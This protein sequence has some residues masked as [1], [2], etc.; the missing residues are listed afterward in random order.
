MCFSN[1]AIFYVKGVAVWRGIK[2]TH[3]LLKGATKL[4]QVNKV[5][6]MY[7]KRGEYINALD[8]FYKVQ[9]TDVRAFSVRQI[10]PYCIWPYRY[11]LPQTM[12]C[13]FQTI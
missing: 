11:Y 3:I 4:P 1:V 13:N 6:K 9:P 12:F 2:A 8:D 10:I 7:A 5:D